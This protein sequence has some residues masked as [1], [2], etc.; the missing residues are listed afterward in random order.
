[1]THNSKL[2][3][4]I[5]ALL[6]ERMHDKDIDMPRSIE[7]QKQLLRSLMN[8]RPPK[9]LSNDIL[10]IQDEYLAEEIRI[11]GVA[12]LDSLTPV[13]KQLY[14]WKGDITTLCVDAIVNAA[15]SQ[16]LGCFVP[17]HGCIDN[18]IHTFA[19]I[20]LRLACADVMQVQGKSEETGKAK[21]TPAFNLPSRYIIH[22]IGPI[23]G[24]RLTKQDC[25]L[26]SSC[27]RSC[28]ELAD[29]KNLHS[30]A[31]CCISTGE[32]HFPNEKAAEI[33]VQTVTSYIENTQSEIKV[34]FNVFKEIDYEIYRRIL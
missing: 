26:L 34:I 2:R 22:T 10:Q 6:H 18:A 19:G 16:M 33:A 5:D 1:M 32:F 24:S 7:E 11:A 13:R 15:N 3:F 29:K 14:L 8:I 20:Q 21:I 17:C 28:L 31:F 30:I 27:Y 12:D 4:L 25:E 23:V 9:P